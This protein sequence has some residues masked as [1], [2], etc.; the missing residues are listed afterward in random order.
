[1]IDYTKDL[2]QFCKNYNIEL[3]G[4]YS[5]VKKITPIYFKCGSCGI[6][7]KK[8]F[9]YLTKY[10]ESPNVCI[11]CGYCHKCFRNIHH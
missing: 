4:E 6:Q 1:M 11:W 7:V 8:S 9:K 10:I 3:I 5:N 2:I